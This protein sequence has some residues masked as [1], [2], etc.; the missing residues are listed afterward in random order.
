MSDSDL[1]AAVGV[2]TPSPAQ[3]PNESS[4]LGVLDGQGF[5]REQIAYRGVVPNPPGPQGT[6]N[7]VSMVTDNN[8]PADTPIDPPVNPPADLPANQS[9]DLP[10]DPPAASASDQSTSF[11]VPPSGKSR[12]PATFSWHK[13]AP[14]PPALEAV[15][16]RPTRPSLPVCG[17]SVPDPSPKVIEVEEDMHMQTSFKRK[18]KRSP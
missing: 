12:P 10:T 17:K 1:L 8:Q 3:P 6:A 9:A 7:H 2:S 13:P 14:M 4:S 15:S 16:C 18:E 5:L 11:P